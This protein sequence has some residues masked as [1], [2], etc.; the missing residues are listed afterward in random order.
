[1]KSFH[2]RTHRPAPEREPAERSPAARPAGM[3]RV[4]VLMVAHKLAA[5]RSLAR[6]LIEGGMVRSEFGVIGKASQ[7]LPLSAQLVL[8][9]AP[10]QEAPQ[11]LDEK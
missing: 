5:S 7:L 1:M 3:E 6:R 8:S 9:A 4:D 10:Q 2:S 11:D